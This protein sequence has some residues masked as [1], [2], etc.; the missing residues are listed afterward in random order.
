[1]NVTLITGLVMLITAILLL[2][3]SAGIVR[4]YYRK[5]YQKIDF[6]NSNV[7]LSTGASAVLIGLYLFMN[8]DFLEQS[9]GILYHREESVAGNIL[10]VFGAFISIGLIA[11]LIAFVIG[12]AMLRYFQGKL[13]KEQIQSDNSNV[14]WAGFFLI[15]GLGLSLLYTCSHFL[16][17]FMPEVS[18]LIH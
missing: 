18:G 6:S 17:F 4:G 1:M 3:L 9:I 15:V 14:A 8:Q 16:L 11:W 2:F 10:A 5:R 12:L 7:A 13:I